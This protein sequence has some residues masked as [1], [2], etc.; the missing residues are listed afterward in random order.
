MKK[1]LLLLLFVF[2]LSVINCQLSIAQTYE[3]SW[4]NYSQEY[5][6]IKVWQDGIYRLTAKFLSNPPNSVPVS[7]WNN[8]NNIQLFHNGTQQYIY[9]YDSD[10]N[11]R[12]DNANDY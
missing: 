1:N 12:I 7:T 11:G 2:Q 6:K 8:I 3:N 4:I 9:V 5:Y 10:G